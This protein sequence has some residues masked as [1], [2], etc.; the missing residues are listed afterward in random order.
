MRVALEAAERFWQT[1]EVENLGHELRLMQM[2]AHVDLEALQR[3]VEKNSAAGPVVGT[4]L[5]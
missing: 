4:K 1:K 3:R 2:M 5:L